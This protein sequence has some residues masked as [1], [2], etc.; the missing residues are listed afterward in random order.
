LTSGVILREVTEGDLPTFFDQQLDSD[1]NHMAAFTAKDPADRNA[2]TARWTKIL[3][4]E[5]I[6]KRTILLGN[7]V[8]GHV[9]S[10]EHFGK[11]EVSYW[12]GKEY[13]GK[14]LAT[15]ALFEFLGHVETRPL[16]ARAAKDNIASI[17]V[18][19]KC[20]FK[21]FREDKGFSNAR[22]EDVEEY[23]LKLDTGPS[24]SARAVLLTPGGSILLMEV[25]GG[26][27]SLWIT[28]GGRRRPGESAGDAV[29]RELHEETGLRRN[30][31]GP[32][33]WVRH[34]T[35]VVDDEKLHERER[36]F[37]FPTEEFKP[38][39]EG[40]EVE[41]R[42]RF[43]S[44]RWWKLADV[45]SSTELFVPRRLGSLLEDLQRNGPPSQPLETGE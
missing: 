23:L 26:E 21:I 43:L 6:T 7:Q 29:V 31:S 8:A 30:Q 38:A 17:R 36:F 28:P 45:V 20:G 14:R 15:K 2:F 34:G 5:T 25:T 10:F 39:R 12:I 27:G 9:L 19:E 40:M 1:A 33:I 16:F 32:E 37:L 22:G 41:E 3:G 42:E 4:D 13:W 44:F 18:L 24:E 35:Y 11:P